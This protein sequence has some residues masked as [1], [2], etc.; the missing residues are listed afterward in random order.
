MFE[1]ERVHC[2]IKKLRM[3]DSNG[4][5]EMMRTGPATCRKVKLALKALFDNF[6]SGLCG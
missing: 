4:F 2:I 1:I 5:K 6:L 3:G